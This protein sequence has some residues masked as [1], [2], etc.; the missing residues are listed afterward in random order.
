MPAIWKIFVWL[1]AFAPRGNLN[2]GYLMQTHETVASFRKIKLGSNRKF[3]LVFGALFA[4]LGVW[5]L[6][7]HADSPKW[8]LIV[9]SAATVA[10]ALLRPAWLT[11]LNLG[12]FKL[13]LALGKIVNPVAMG[14]LFFGAVVPVGRYLRWKGEDL[15]RLKMNPQAG[16]YWI[17]RGP[18]YPPPDSMKKQF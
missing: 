1:A 12:W 15:L 8:G 11:L 13:G 3:G 7:H 10:V 4:I 6:F 17:E 18:P 9:L 14:I 5:P 2:N 16:T